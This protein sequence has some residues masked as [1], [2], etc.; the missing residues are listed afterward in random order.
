MTAT[1]PPNT[2]QRQFTFLAAHTLLTTVLD[3]HDSSL[4]SYTNVSVNVLPPVLKWP[5]KHPPEPNSLLS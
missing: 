2:I 1:L 5:A 3:S 4:G